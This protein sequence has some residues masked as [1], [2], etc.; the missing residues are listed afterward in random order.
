MVSFIFDTGSKLT[1]HFDHERQLEKKDI[2]LSQDIRIIKVIE[3]IIVSEGITLY[4]IHDIL[5][6]KDEILLYCYMERQ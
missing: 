6:D 4:D 1:D 2:N 3:K 5:E